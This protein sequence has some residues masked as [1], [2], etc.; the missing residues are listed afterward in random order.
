MRTSSCPPPSKPLVFTRRRFIQA[1]TAAAAF[2]AASWNRVA[3][4]NERVGIGV[5]GFGLIGRIHTRNFK[6]QPDAQIL[7]MAE[8]YKPRLEAGAALVG[9]QVAQY[10]DF[11]RLLENKQ[12]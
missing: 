9:G 10:G 4:A 12:V 2:T 1:S 3:G 11:R 8:T 7:A 5:I 6:A